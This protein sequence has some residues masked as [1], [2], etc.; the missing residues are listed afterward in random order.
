MSLEKF[1]KMSLEKYKISVQKSVV[2]LYTNKN[3][4]LEFF[5]K[6]NSIMYEILRNMTKIGKDFYDE[7]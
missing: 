2:F 5:G 1:R 6:K 3:Q 4:I 7:H